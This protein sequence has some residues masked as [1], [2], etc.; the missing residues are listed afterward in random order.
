MIVAETIA[1]PLEARINYRRALKMAIASAMR[2]GAEGIRGACIRPY[3]RCG[4]RPVRKNTNKDVRRFHT[5]RADIDYAFY[6]A[7]T[8]Y[9]SDRI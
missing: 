3:R 8:V 1:K 4:N 6:E 2:M 5:W 9:G 7:L